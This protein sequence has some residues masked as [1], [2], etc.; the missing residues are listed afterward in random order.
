[1]VHFPD[2]FQKVLK[3]LSLRVGLLFF[4]FLFLFFCFVWLLLSSYKMTVGRWYVQLAG[5]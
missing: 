3:H 2:F 5:I 4:C 1:M